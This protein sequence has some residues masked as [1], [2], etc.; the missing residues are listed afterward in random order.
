MKNDL[1][2]CGASES[3]ARDSDF[4]L[5]RA[6]SPSGRSQDLTTLFVAHPD[7]SSLPSV[8]PPPQTTATRHSFLAILRNHSTTP[9]QHPHCSCAISSRPL[10]SVG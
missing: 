5:N 3:Y 7:N 1:V 4:R 10:S 6:K 2:S 9:A 8:P